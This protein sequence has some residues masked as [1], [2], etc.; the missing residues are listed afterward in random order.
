MRVHRAGYPQA[1]PAGGLFGAWIPAHARVLWITLG[2][3]AAAL[4]V[5][6]WMGAGLVILRELVR[7]FVEVPGP[8]PAPLGGWPFP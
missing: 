2:L 1:F 7:W 5:L 8:V 6:A 4:L 3:V